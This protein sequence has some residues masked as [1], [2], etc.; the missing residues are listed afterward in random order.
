MNLTIIEDH[1]GTITSDERPASAVS[2]VL[3]EIAQVLT[4]G[5]AR[6]GHEVLSGITLHFKASTKRSGPWAARQ[7]GVVRRKFVDAVQVDHLTDEQVEQ[8]AAIFDKDQ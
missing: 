1:D 3:A 4:D 2:L 6:F 8:V 5:E 7:A